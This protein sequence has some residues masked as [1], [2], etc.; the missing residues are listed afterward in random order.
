MS[1]SPV[2]DSLKVN[3]LSIKYI[4]KM[5]ASK[6]YFIDFRTSSKLDI[7]AKL[8]KLLVKAGFNDFD[9]D[10]KMTALKLHFGEPGNMA[11]LRPNYAAVV[12]K[13]VQEKGG[14]PFLTD[15]NTLYKGRRSNGI[16]HLQTAMENGFNPITTGC[17]VV[18][19]DGIKGTEYREIEI[20][21]KH[22][23]TAKIGSAIADSDVLISLTHFKGHEMAGFGGCLKNVGMGSGSIG[24]K[25]EMHSDSK[26]VIQ[27]ESCTACKV[28]EKYCAHDAIHIVDKKAVID[29]KKCV[30]CGQCVS[31]CMFD[32]AQVQWDARKMQEK[33]AEY[34]LAVLK[35][36][37]A[38][39]INFIMDVSP[40]CDCWGFNDAPIVP[41][42][43]ILAS[44]DPVAIDHASVDMVNQAP[45]NPNCSI[46]NHNH[47]DRFS[48]AH[49]NTE[50]KASL[51]HAEEIGLGTINYEL[52]KVE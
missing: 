11:Y 36:K 37:P 27:T 38:L 41:N 2:S 8:R 14:K 44:T 28:C 32:A 48:L 47:G 3:P 16:D 19:A 33:M 6:V 34:A 9:F 52:I 30:G 5:P 40:N 35:N 26:P 25:L 4:K 42:I 12:A 17:N 31:V 20:N 21:Q 46:S 29:Y 45:I 43:G 7:L 50:W 24:G 49:P 1:I 13:M 22:C 51:S 23:K 10:R 39:H 15:A 18:I